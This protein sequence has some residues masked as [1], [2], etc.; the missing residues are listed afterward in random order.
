MSETSWTENQEFRVEAMHV[1]SGGIAEDMDRLPDQ[2]RR[3]LVTI[4]TSRYVARSRN[5][6]GWEGLLAYE[7]EIRERL[8]EMFLE[9]VVD[10]DAE[11]AFKR[12]QDGDDVPKLLRRDRP[13]TRDSSFLL[14]FLRREF[15]YVEPGNPVVVSRDQLGGFLRAFREDGDSNEAKF[16]RRVDAAIS[17]LVKPLQLLTPDLAADYLFTVA[18]VVPALVGIDEI[19]RL[20]ATYRKATENAADG[21]VGVVP[22]EEL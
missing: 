19:A 22:E 10:R 14:I 4:L 3:A 2:G 5:R 18:P 15:A 9:L 11:V 6:A 13:L 7:G 1:P 20:E 21:S 16:A 17:G 12:Q 8:D